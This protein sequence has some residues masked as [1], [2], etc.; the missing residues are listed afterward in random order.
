M[1]TTISLSDICKV[2]EPDPE[3]DTSYLEKDDF[4]DHLAAYSRGEFTHVGVWAEVEVYVSGVRQ[5]IRSGGLW[6]IEDN[7]SVESAKYLEEVFAEERQ[8]LIDILA[9]LNITAV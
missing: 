5:I 9:A 4:K 7:G 3:A 1:P 6:G 8:A 2:V